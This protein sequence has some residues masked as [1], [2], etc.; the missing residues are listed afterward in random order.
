LWFVTGVTWIHS[1]TVA[2]ILR[3]RSALETLR[4]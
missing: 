4:E 3:S 2:G 1:W